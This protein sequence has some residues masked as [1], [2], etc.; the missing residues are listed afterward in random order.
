[1]LES[2]VKFELRLLRPPTSDSYR[3]EFLY[4]DEDA[5]EEK[6]ASRERA[7]S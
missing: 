2:L 3:Y 6:D 5:V 4:D 1:M 7:M